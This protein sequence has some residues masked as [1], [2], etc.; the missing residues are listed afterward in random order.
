[1]F[2]DCLICVAGVFVWP[3]LSFADGAECLKEI[4]PA[5]FSRHKIKMK[6]LHRIMHKL[7]SKRKIQGGTWKLSVSEHISLISSWVSSATST[8]IRQ[9]PDVLIKVR[10]KRAGEQLQRKLDQIN[11]RLTKSCSSVWD[12]W[13]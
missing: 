8:Q 1:M 7:P 6:P 11:T 3:S 12:Q 9:L 4:I 5:F 13:I 10:G 2:C